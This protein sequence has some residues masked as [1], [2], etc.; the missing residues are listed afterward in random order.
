MS[1]TAGE[2][3]AVFE[4]AGLRNTYPRRLIAE[5]LAQLSAKGAEFATEDLWRALVRMEPRLGRAT[6]FRAV[7]TLLG[8]GV[9]DRVTFA[10]GTHRYRVCGSAGEHH[11]HHLTCVECRRVIEVDACLPDP[12]LAEI[13]RTTHFS[14][15]GHSVS[16]FGRCPAC[17]DRAAQTA[18]F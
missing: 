8:Q 7:E 2:I 5:K 6:V 15:E 17:R 3:R 9:L 18:Q 1:V 13:E 12:L 16:L 4:Q 11:H 14:L 10:D